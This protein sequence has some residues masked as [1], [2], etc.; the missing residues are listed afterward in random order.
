MPYYI[1]SGRD[2]TTKKFI[3]TTGGV[4]ISFGYLVRSFILKAVGGVINL[5]KLAG[6]SDSDAFP[7]GDGESIAVDIT[8]PYPAASN[9]STLG[10]AFTNSGTVDV[11]VIAVF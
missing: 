6:D 4:T 11:Y 9:T 10:I 8:V 3:A 2:Y 7:I 1:A 5:K